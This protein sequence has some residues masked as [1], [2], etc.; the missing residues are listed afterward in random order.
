MPRLER[1]D[2]D[3]MTFLKHLFHLR[4][5]TWPSIEKYRFRLG[6]VLSSLPSLRTLEVK[7]QEAFLTDQLLGA[8]NPKLTVIDITGFNLKHI[9]AKAFNGIEDN[10]ELIL[11]IHDTQ[12]E[13]LPPGLSSKLFKV[14]NLSLDLRNNKFTSLS[15][16]SLYPNSTFEDGGT[17]LISGKNIIYLSYYYH[18]T[19]ILHFLTFIQVLL[20]PTFITVI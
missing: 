8:F 17:R 6:S 1:F 10:T 4:T 2:T 13:D 11:R 9:D 16:R 5:Q 20:G 3:S 14:I 19:L 18:S 12:I 7:I 15:P